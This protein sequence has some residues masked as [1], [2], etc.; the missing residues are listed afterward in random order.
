[1][2]PWLS[3]NLILSSSSLRICNAVLRANAEIVS[4]L[5]Q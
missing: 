5:E 1:M 4:G 2:V 3:F